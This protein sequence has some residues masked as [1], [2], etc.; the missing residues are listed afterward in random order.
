MILLLRRYYYFFSL[1]SRIP[2]FYYIICS[3]PV[4]CVNIQFEHDKLVIHEY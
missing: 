2:F 1:E 3:Y 4:A